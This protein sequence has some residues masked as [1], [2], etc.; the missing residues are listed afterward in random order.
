MSSM[1]SNATTNTTNTTNPA[2]HM[3][4]AA[5]SQHDYQQLIARFPGRSREIDF[6]LNVICHVRLVPLI[7]SFYSSRLVC[8]LVYW[9]D[10]WVGFIGLFVLLSNHHDRLADEVFDD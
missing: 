8:G 10:Y 1:R 4:N 5:Y 3:T 2:A 7:D 9:V 6:L